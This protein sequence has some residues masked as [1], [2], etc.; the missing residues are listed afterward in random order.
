MTDDDSRLIRAAYTSD[1]VTVYQAYAPQIASAAV[2]AGTFVPPFSQD[3]MTWIKPSFGWMMHRSG[4]AGKPGQERVLAIEITRA[5]FEWALA[6]SCLSHYSPGVHASPQA[7]AALKDASPV[8]IQWDPDRVLSGEQL[9]RRAIQV[10]LS[11]EA[12]RRYCG[13]W[14]RSITDIT[15]V[16]RAIGQLVRPTGSPTPRVNCQPSGC[17]HWTWR[18][19]GRIGAD[20]GQPAPG[21]ETD[22]GTMITLRDRYHGCLLSG[23]VGDALGAAV[24]F[25]SLTEIRHRHGPAG[26][27]GYVPAY[28]RLGA[29][30][31]DT[32]MTLF[33][34]EGLLRDQRHRRAARH[35]R[36]DL[37]RIPRWLNTQE[38]G[39]RPAGQS[40]GWLTSR[41]FLHA[42]RAPGNTCLSAL[43]AGQPGTLLQRVNDS[44]G[45][46]GVM[47]VAPTG[48]ADGNPFTLGCQAAAL[49][50]GH[51]SGYYS[52]GAF[53]VMVSELVPA[54]IC[55]R[56]SPPH[57]THCAA[58]PCRPS[59]RK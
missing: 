29:I 56:R 50:H 19:P 30:T 47:R 38:D 31:D 58:S 1:T 11:D 35:A 43:R 45:C 7:W 34:A 33:T 51:P 57:S 54:P 39:Q 55:A 49:T 32:Q 40:D 6:H 24:E 5:G 20:A 13:E 12:V 4:W 3:R 21:D 17:T 9:P 36:R 16:A 10:G 27:T 37:A 8:R 15:A 26:V 59:R 23:A 22:G 44:K 41:G 48:L 42:E 18:W 25:L 46:G 53:A 2:R 14:I 52:A 28:G